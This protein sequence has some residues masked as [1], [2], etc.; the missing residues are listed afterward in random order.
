MMRRVNQLSIVGTLK[1]G[2]DRDAF[3]A[4]VSQAWDRQETDG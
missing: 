1:Q 4:V 3:V 2:V